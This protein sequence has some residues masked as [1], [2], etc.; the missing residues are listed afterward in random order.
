MAQTTDTH[1]TSSE[2]ENLGHTGT[3]T[4]A[5]TEHH[6]PHIP[7]TQG[8]RIEGFFLG[9]I[10][11]TNTILS[12]WIFMVFLFLMVGTM[13]VAM[14]TNMFPRVRALG[15]DIV[16]KFDTFLTG[17]LG[18][19]RVARKFLPLVAGFFIF[20]F[21]GNVF[22]LIFDWINLAF[23]A[24]HAYLR[25]INSDLNTTFVLAVTTIVVAQLTGIFHKGFFH[26]FGHYLF[27]FS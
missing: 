10:A 17:A 4:H 24:M 23:P 6:G 18:E 8:E 1:T 12:T 13:F 26:H 20:I 14:K 22:G 3:E 16:A 5:T 19:K 27:N 11:I 25:P 21:L 9:D 7:G 15:L 2:A